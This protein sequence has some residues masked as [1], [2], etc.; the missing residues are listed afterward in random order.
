LTNNG[1]HRFFITGP[2]GPVGI[3]G[4][5]G[6]DGVTGPIGADG[7]IGSTGPTGFIRT[8]PTGSVRTGPTGAGSLVTGPTGP[9]LTGPT[10]PVLTGP[11]GADNTVPGP[12]G[13]TGAVQTGSTGAGSLVTGPT[14]PVMTGPTG[15]VMT[16]PTGASSTVPGPTG[17]TGPTGPTG[18]AFTGPTGVI[19]TGP[20]G[21]GNAVS[22][23]YFLR[24]G[25][26][27]L[28]DSGSTG[29]RLSAF[30]VKDW[31]THN[32]A[33]TGPPWLFTAPVAGK[34]LV[35]VAIEILDSGSFDVG[36]RGQIKIVTNYSNSGLVVYRVWMQASPSSWAYTTVFPVII[37]LAVND[38]VHVVFYQVSGS[39]VYLNGNSDAN[40]I[41]VQQLS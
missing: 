1:L 11:T 6:F 38:T 7:Y 39:T 5:I 15:P 33:V 41:A 40:W 3:D 13:L 12:I 4:Y 31:D 16:G 32:A 14:G 18:I 24:T 10:G 19:Q 35:I 34:Y 20:T 36:D 27:G 37:D 25:P 21:A 8:G 2:T 29:T 30:N 23:R 22:C 28:A 26:T 9:V 17:V